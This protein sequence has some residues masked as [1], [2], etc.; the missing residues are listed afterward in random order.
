MNTNVPN[1]KI[2]NSFS[3]KTSKV[4]NLQNHVNAGK[5]KLGNVVLSKL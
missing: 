4:M 1:A 5:E 3:I 2:R